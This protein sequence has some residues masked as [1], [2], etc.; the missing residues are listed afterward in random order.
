MIGKHLLIT[1]RS[2]KKNLLYALFVIVGLAIGITTFLS[3]VQWSAWH[4]TFDRD[5][6]DRERIYRLTFEEINE[7][8]Y[9]HTAR[10][11]HGTAL[12]R[13]VFSE[14]LP[15]IE[16]L[17]RL[18]PFRNAAF[19]IGED[20]FYDQ[21][22]F[23]CDRDFLE[24]FQP[25]IL[26]GARENLLGEPFTAILTE[27]T[28]NKFFGPGEAVGK[29]FELIH[30][31]GIEPTTYRVTAVIRDFPENS[32]LKISIL[33]TFENPVEYSGTAWAYMKLQ[34]SAN[35]GEIEDQIKIFLESNLE[36]DY[37]EQ[38]HPR[39][40]A[41]GDIHLHSH[42]AREIQPNI[43]FRTILILMIAGI[44]VFLL[45][46]FNFTLLAFSQNQMKIQRFVVQW[47][48][49]AD[50]QVFLRQFMVDNLFVG[51]LSFVTGILI[52]L[53]LIP[54][55]ENQAG[56]HI[57]KDGRILMCSLMLLLLLIVAGSFI[58]SLLS[59]RRIYR[60]LQQK[61]LFSRQ[62]SPPEN[63]RKNLFI[64][65]VIVLEFIITFVLLSNLVMISRQTGYAMAE[66]LGA[67]NPEVIH[68]P[69]LHRAIVDKFGI[70]KEKMLESPAVKSVTAS[71]EEPTGQS[72]DANT[73]EIDG[74]SE[75]DKQLFLFPVDENFFRFYGL[76]IVSGSDFPENYDPDDSAEYFVLNET[77]ARM[78]TGNPEE[79]IG[80]ELTLHFSYQ[81]FIWPGPVTGIVEDF[82]LSGLDFEISPMVI[83]PKYTWLWCFSVM[84]SGDP[85]ATLDHLEVVWNELFSEYPLEYSFSS[86]LI[87]QLYGAELV[88]KRMLIIFSVLSII[89]AGMGLFA[90]SGFFMQKRIKA[91]MLRKIHGARIHHII[92]PELMYY[93]WLALVSSAISIPASYLLMER[94]MRNFKYR[95]DIPLWIFPA[96]VLILVIFSWIAVSLHTWRLAR[97]NPVDF[98]TE[99]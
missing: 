90:M 89:I 80:R 84:P 98:I 43:R 28:A 50:R 95:T 29:S 73:F 9:R 53:I 96:C 25:A 22:A 52:T 11:L 69:N 45:A 24:I 85:S 67:T 56:T 40:Q 81:G 79:L 61:F 46:W 60:H 14:M 35:P 92:V 39:L 8:F 44:L 68:L 86:S 10:I 19:L 27:S 42:K 54:T 17:G 91:A 37:A 30:Q 77:A 2:L 78:L 63:T 41:V 74:I 15:G 13:M 1:L 26:Q 6:P 66:Q 71:M 4:L 12:N 82:H 23:E 7:G 21:Y 59:T 55:I 57:F 5:Y 75:G 47:Q 72:M 48:M 16:K 64:R 38:L 87:E 18:A 97:T 65:A 83:F 31:F 93:L 36:E 76:R 49:G 34:E 33:T 88:Q 32:H 3:T 94:W 62:G 99:Q 51:T 58:T 20:S 70:F